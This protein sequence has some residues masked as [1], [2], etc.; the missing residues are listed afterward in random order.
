M[1]RIVVSNTKGGVGKSTIARSI[2]DVLKSDVIDLD[3]QKTLTQSAIIS[4]KKKPISPNEAKGKYLVY[5][6][7]PY[8]TGEL[9][10]ILAIADYLLVPVKSGFG[11][12]LATQTL[13]KE[14]KTRSNITR[15]G[16]F[17]NDVRKPVDNLHKEIKEHFRT[18]YK[19]L[20]LDTEISQ[21]SSF[22]NVL[23]GDL[24]NKAKG[25]IEDLLKEIGIIN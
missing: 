4:G 18:N 17:F 1:I 21:L 23:N 15:I 24:T 20:L 11:D 16:I 13:I 19:D 14:A 8:R 5:D 3:S 22:R 10:D 6:T 25:Q 12:L 2:A 7:P 9:R